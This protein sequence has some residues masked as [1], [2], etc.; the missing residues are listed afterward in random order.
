MTENR[1]AMDPEDIIGK[2]GVVN[3]HGAYATRD[4]KYGL[5][6]HFSAEA[7]LYD[8]EAKAEVIGNATGLRI[9][10]VT[11]LRS[12]TAQGSDINDNVYGG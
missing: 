4:T 8:T 12:V 1:K 10:Q 5:W 2:W 11:G 7:L 3:K 6:T 9:E